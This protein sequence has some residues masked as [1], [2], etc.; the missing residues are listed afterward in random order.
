MITLPQDNVHKNL[1]D[2]TKGPFSLDDVSVGK[3]DDE[4]ANEVI[5]DT[6]EVKMM[7]QNKV[8]VT[9]DATNKMVVDE[10][11]TVSI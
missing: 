9:S 10:T 4:G 7:A 8:Q 6:K 2:D 11:T 3:C 1:Q 5:V